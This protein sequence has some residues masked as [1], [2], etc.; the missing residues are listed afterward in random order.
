MKM[1]PEGESNSF[2]LHFIWLLIFQ[3]EYFCGGKLQD[4]YNTDFF[5][6]QYLPFDYYW[7]ISVNWWGSDVL[8]ARYEV[9]DFE[10]S[11]SS[12][13]SIVEKKMDIWC[14]HIF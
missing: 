14:W 3:S 4:T 7:L 10:T 5:I 13:R 8:F 9:D 2:E 12:D 11:F 1:I 6:R